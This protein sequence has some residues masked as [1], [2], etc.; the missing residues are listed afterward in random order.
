VL[1]SLIPTN[2]VNH[3]D[4]APWLSNVDQL[5]YFPYHNHPEQHVADTLVE[6]RCHQVPR[7]TFVNYVEQYPSLCLLR[8]AIAIHNQVWVEVLVLKVKA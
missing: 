1:F 8:W 2:H 7:V 6:G 5:T 3:Q 4:I